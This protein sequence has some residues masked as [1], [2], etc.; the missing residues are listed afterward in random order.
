MLPGG[1]GNVRPP[2]DSGQLRCGT[3]WETPLEW[4]SPQDLQKTQVF[5][6]RSDTYTSEMPLAVLWFGH[7]RVEIMGADLLFIRRSCY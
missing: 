3:F 7:S 5:R 1:R 4:N 2:A 6:Q